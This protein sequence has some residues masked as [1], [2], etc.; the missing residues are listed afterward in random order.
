MLHA[1][2]ETRKVAWQWNRVFLI[3]LNKFHL[4]NTLFVTHL[5][6]R[7]SDIV[8]GLGQLLDH[9]VGLFIPGNGLGLCNQ[10]E[11]LRNQT[12]LESSV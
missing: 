9:E 2:F 10:H 8:C 11:K 12:E 4:P 3:I 6:W 5:D 1:A 7:G